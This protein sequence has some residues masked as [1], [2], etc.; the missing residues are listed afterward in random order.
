VGGWVGG[1]GVECCVEF[2]AT[3]CGAFL[4]ILCRIGGFDAE[5]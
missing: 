3:I 5:I 2:F 4:G 1:E